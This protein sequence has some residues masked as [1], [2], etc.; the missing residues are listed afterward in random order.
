[1]KTGK[2][3]M[4]MSARGRYVPVTERVDSTMPDRFH[5]SENAR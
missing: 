5:G 4:D 3:I 1:M 2:L